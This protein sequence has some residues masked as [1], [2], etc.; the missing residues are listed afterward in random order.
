MPVLQTE[1]EGSAETGRTDATEGAESAG[2]IIEGDTPAAKIAEWV[3]QKLSSGE[4]F[5]FADLTEIANEAFG[6]TQAEGKYIAKDAYDAME[7]GVNK[8]LLKQTDIDF[9]VDSAEQVK[10]NV[11]K[12]GLA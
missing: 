1:S 9:T 11:Q 4:R 7:L 2:G 12:L 3:K 6:G 10:E 8:Y 5:T